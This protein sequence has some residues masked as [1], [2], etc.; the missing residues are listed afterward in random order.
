M[1]NNRINHEL[2][3]Y[4]RRKIKRE[5]IT[6]LFGIIDRLRTA[7]NR[8]VKQLT[9]AES[10][11][12]KERQKFTVLEKRYVYRLLLWLA[13]YLVSIFAAFYFYTL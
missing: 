1:E 12:I 2:P 5:K 8:L 10:L 4:K 13:L 11:V 7:N 9:E 6:F 3:T